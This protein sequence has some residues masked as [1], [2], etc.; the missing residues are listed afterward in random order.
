MRG[1]LDGLMVGF[2]LSS[3]EVRVSACETVRS[4]STSIIKVHLNQ[5]AM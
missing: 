2:L 4:A 3:V 1:R 5:S